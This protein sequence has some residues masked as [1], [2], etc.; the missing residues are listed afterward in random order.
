MEVYPSIDIKDGACVRLYQGDY[1]QVTIYDQDPVAVALR[2]QDRGG[3]ILHVVDL[4][5]AATGSQENL[6][7]IERI[8]RALRIPVQIGGG[9]RS[10]DIVERLFDIGV[11]RAIFGTVAVRNPEVVFAAIDRWGDRIAVSID[12]RNGKATTDGW[13][14]TSDIDAFALAVSLVERGLTTVVYTDISRDGTLTEPNYEAMQAMAKKVAPIAVI[15]SGGVARLEHV[16]RLADTGVIG[17][18]VGRSL[19]AGTLD[20]AEALAWCRT[21]EQSTC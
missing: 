21:Q 11:S 8:V 14:E 12:A 4:D 10:N 7:V 15:A 18:I 20:L 3:S 1:N 16:R 9:V 17:V 19:Y 13:T 6:P 5:G 2:W